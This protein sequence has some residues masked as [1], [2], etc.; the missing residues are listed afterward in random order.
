LSWFSALARV[1]RQQSI[2]FGNKTQDM[3]EVDDAWRLIRQTVRLG[4]AVGQTPHRAGLPLIINRRRIRPKVA[5]SP[6]WLARGRGRLR[7]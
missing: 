1:S 6:W 4:T 2:L 5:A 7:N 3:V